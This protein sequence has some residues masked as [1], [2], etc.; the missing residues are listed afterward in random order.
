MRNRQCDTH[1]QMS[2]AY[3]EKISS[4]GTSPCCAKLTLTHRGQ[5]VV[6]RLDHLAYLPDLVKEG[7]F[8]YIGEVEAPP[9]C[10]ETPLGHEVL[11]IVQAR[12]LLLVTGNVIIV[13]E[14]IGVPSG[15][16]GHQ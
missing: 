8:L 2:A 10:N 15:T 4:Q 13:P 14:L 12:V 1:C 11:E 7:R 9:D 6:P 16:C 5:M 3:G